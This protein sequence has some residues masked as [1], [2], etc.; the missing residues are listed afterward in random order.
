[1]TSGPRGRSR[2]GQILRQ[3]GSEELAERRGIAGAFL[4]RDDNIPNAVI[5]ERIDPMGIAIGI[6]QRGEEFRFEAGR[7]VLPIDFLQEADLPDGAGDF[8]KRCADPGCV[9]IEQWK[10]QYPPR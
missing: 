5:R 10:K 8:T 9:M 7:F 2:C 6:D 4:L 3:Q 1:M